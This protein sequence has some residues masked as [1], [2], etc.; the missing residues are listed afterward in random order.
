MSNPPSGPTNNS[1]ELLNA[2]VVVTS[3]PKDLAKGLATDPVPATTG[4]PK[5]VTPA[6]T[7]AVSPLDA[8]DPGLAPQ[9]STPSTSVPIK[10][11]SKSSFHI[12]GRHSSI[13][14][15]ASPSA[16]SVSIHGRHTS[17]VEILSAPPPLSPSNANAK[18]HRSSID[19]LDPNSANA[20]VSR[21][22]SNNSVNTM[23]S[24][25]A[26]N[27]Q[28][29][30]L[31]DLVEEAKLIFIQGDVS[32]E[33]GYETL[34]EH[35]LTSVPVIISPSNPNCLTFDYTDVNGY[36]L[37]MMNKFL[38][39]ESSIKSM[40][41]TGSVQSEQEVG[42][43]I[44]RAKNGQSVP[45]L[46][47]SQLAAKNPFLRFAE[48]NTL[49]NIV[50]VLGSGV[51]RI[52]ITANDD[53]KHIVG[54]LSQRR[55]MKYIWENGRRFKGLETLFQTSLADL[56]IGSKKLVTINGEDNVIDAFYKMHV[57]GISSLAV[58]DSHD[59][60]LGN[61]SVTD[62]QQVTKSSQSH[63]LFK[64]CLHFISVILNSRGLDNGKDSF[65]IFHVTPNTS[66]GRTIAKLVAT[67]AHRL[68]I[69]QPYD[70]YNLPPTNSLSSRN[71]IGN[72][73]LI[74][75]V[76]LTD[77]L[78]V[79]SNMAG[80][81]AVDPHHARKQRRSSSSS[82]SSRSSFDATLGLGRSERN[83]KR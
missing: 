33:E 55:L 10:Y 65:P 44:T 25:V 39:T 53:D 46:F 69:V 9:Q 38:P 1:P 27:W 3:P 5:S 35:N 43:F 64:S 79:L 71:E 7:P 80:N 61:I 14:S 48:S 82:V 42:E 30:T 73:K 49:A 11:P 24:A 67:R 77:I 66:L 70:E 56:K 16:G 41:D 13:V 21:S 75:V 28:D 4:H 60:L 19:N 34:M 37:L 17:I 45:V 57:D 68:W 12:P 20:S 50:Q 72:G 32:V 58:V 36:L 18:L 23:S 15:A 74:G 78:G 26:I 81:N 62:V 40:I 47:V 63:I 31:S 59:H 6:V 8:Q 51:H 22:S 52:A 83:I 54:I 29:V 76:S 2:P